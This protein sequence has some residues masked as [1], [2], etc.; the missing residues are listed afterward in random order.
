VEWVYYF[1]PYVALVGS[2]QLHATAALPLGKKLP[3]PTGLEAG[4]ATA[5]LDAMTK[6]KKTPLLPL[7]LL[8]NEYRLLF[9]WG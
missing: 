4:W 3:V 7:N 6:R 2:G 9:P 1:T 5:G 8:S